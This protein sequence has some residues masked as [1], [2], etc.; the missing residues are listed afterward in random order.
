[1]DLW[2]QGTDPFG[3]HSCKDTRTHKSPG[4]LDRHSTMAAM[5]SQTSAG[6]VLQSR[7][8]T[9]IYTIF[10]IRFLDIQRH[11]TG[12]SHVAVRQTRLPSPVYLI[13]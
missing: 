1:M 11:D 9:R 13:R 6:A 2:G 5:H 10:T 12:S 4:A 3:R 8:Q 7:H